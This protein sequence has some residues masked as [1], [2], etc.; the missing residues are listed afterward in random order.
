MT[1]FSFEN[2]FSAFSRFGY[3]TR[4]VKT[5]AETG[6]TAPFHTELRKARR[7]GQVRSFTVDSMGRGPTSSLSL[8]IDVD[9]RR[10]NVGALTMVA[11][12]PDWFLAIFKLNVVGKNGMYKKRMSGNLFVYDA[13]T[14]SGKTFMSEDEPTRP[15]QNIAPFF[16]PQFNRMYLGKYSLKKM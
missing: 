7:N 6:N 10:R 15:R 3:A 16:G 11:P 12:S 9:C 4:G 8:V 5:V 1:L 13:G 14:D 2:R